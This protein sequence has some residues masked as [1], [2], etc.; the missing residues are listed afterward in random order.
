MKKLLIYTVLIVILFSYNIK[1]YASDYNNTKRET[2][3]VW[4]TTVYNKDWPSIENKNNIY[5]QKQEFINILD[6]VKNLGFNTVVVQVRPK[7]DA[8]YKSSI[9][10]WADV[11]TGIQGKDPG[12]DPLEFMVDEAHKR[13]LEIHAWFNPYRITTSGTDLGI[14]NDNNKA[15]QNPSWVVSSKSGTDSSGNDLYALYYN[16]GLPQVR[17][18]LL[19]TIEEVVHNYDI[20]GIHFDD[21]FYPSKNFNDSEA[22]NKYGNGLSLDDFRRDSV[23]KLIKD[24]NKLINNVNKDIKFG[25]SPR[26]IWKNSSSDSTGSQTSGGQSYYDIYADTRTWIENKW[27]DYVTPQLYWEI[28]NKSADYSKLISWWSKEVE[29]KPIHLYIGQGV[30]KPVVSSQIK[31]QIDLNRTYKNIKGSMFYTWS[32]IEDNINGCKDTISKLYNEYAIPHNMEWKDKIPPS[33]PK[34]SINKYSD[35]NEIE[36]NRTSSDTSYYLI[37]RFDNKESININNNNKIIGDV[38]SEG[39]KSTYIDSDIELGKE[40]TYVVTALDRMHNE[41]EP[42]I[43]NTNKYYL[44]IYTFYGKESVESAIN[45]LEKETGWYLKSEKITTDKSSFRLVT[46]EFNSKEIAKEEASKLNKEKGWWV[47]YEPTSNGKYRLITGDFYGEQIAKDFAM[48]L[49]EEKDWWV[50]YEPTSEKRVVEDI[51]LK[52]RIITGE[53]NGESQVKQAIENLNQK[54]GWWATYEPTSNGKYRIVT[55]EFIGESSVNSA[56]EFINKEFMWWCKSEQTGNYV[57]NYRIT[58]GDFQNIDVAEEKSN[59]I[60][61]KYNWHNE[62]RKRY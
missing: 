24:V 31:E 10:P 9:N 39:S 1:I 14:L 21:Y 11:L 58:T 38:R 42:S 52:Y 17:Q 23:N 30:Y 45:T 48:K 47:S 27:I 54:T 2:R 32:D 37:Y 18:Y 51:T 7:G 3:A 13:N 50:S 49:S 43:Y 59:F 25:V 33:S 53:F 40:Y 60:K 8:L 44:D 26:G 20:D 16:P 62:I 15:K 57:N 46:G 56:I 22:Y 36:I 35:R 41:S 34:I 12:Y 4:I 19:D 55:G 6:E 29:Y 61:N 5:K 28:G